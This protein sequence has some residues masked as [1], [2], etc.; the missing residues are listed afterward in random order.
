MARMLG[1]A[2]ACWL[3]AGAVTACG[4][5]PPAGGPGSVQSVAG[6]YVLADPAPGM[7][8]YLGATPFFSEPRAAAASAPRPGDGAR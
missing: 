1:Q 2:W 8:V 5:E 4:S 3:V 7:T 6:G